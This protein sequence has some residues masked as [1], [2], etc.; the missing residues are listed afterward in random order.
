MENDKVQ[1]VL[2]Q[3]Y[4]VLAKDV[5]QDQRVRADGKSYEVDSPEYIGGA[6]Q[7]AHL[8]LANIDSFITS[9]KLRRQSEAFGLN[10]DYVCRQIS[11][12]CKEVIQLADKGLVIPTSLD[13]QL[14]NLFLTLLTVKAEALA[15][16]DKHDDTV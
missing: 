14:L 10:H 8:I 13:N 2:D 7:A 1:E 11:K 15:Q 4:E 6:G 9:D 12:A 16:E 3:A 5:P